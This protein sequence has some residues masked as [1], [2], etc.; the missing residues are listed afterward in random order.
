[1]GYSKALRLNT[2]E[3]EAILTIKPREWYNLIGHIYNSR[4]LKNH[5]GDK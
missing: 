1:M 3:Y 5:W 4:V 2:G